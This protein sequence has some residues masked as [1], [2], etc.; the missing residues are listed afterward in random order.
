MRRCSIL[1]F[2]N[3]VP[4]CRPAGKLEAAWRS[5]NQE[6]LAKTSLGTALGFNVCTERYARASAAV[7]LQY[8]GMIGGPI[9]GSET[10]RSAAPKRKGEFG[11]K[12]A[13]SHAMPR[14]R[15]RMRMQHAKDDLANDVRRQRLKVGI[16]RGACLGLHHHC[17]L[18]EHQIEAR[19]GGLV[20]SSAQPDVG[21][22]VGEEIGVHM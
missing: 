15:A 2:E 18:S 14:R 3:Q 12:L 4:C 6:A 16:S 22:E 21:W 17:S 8:E 1:S 11:L 13:R 7:S 20:Q 10:V 5:T 19:I 9:L